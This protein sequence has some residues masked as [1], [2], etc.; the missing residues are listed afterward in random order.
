M[1][2]GASKAGG[3]GSASPKTQRD[4]QIDNL[5]Q[6]IWRGSGKAMHPSQL[7]VG[8]RIDGVQYLFQPD[9]LNPTQNKGMWSGD[10]NG[11]KMRFSADNTFMVNSVVNRGNK[12]I[13]TVTKLG[14]AGGT[15][16][17]TLSNDVYLRVYK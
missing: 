6:N 1:G 9:V 4:I 10:Y 13:I 7:N 16:K 3:G 11:A 2:R 8:D 17:K 15:A 12:T 5:E 14:G